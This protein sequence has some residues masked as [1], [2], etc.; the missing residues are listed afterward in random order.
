[1]SPNEVKAYIALQMAMGLC[2]KNE[3]ADYWGQFRLTLTPFT[4]IISCN[5]YELLTSFLHFANY[6]NARPT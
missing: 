2:Q 6:E 5:R 3:Q 1:M 4:E